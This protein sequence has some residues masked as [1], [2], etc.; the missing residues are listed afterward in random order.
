MKIGT[1]DKKKVIAASVLGFFGIVSAIF[2]YEQIF[3]GP[4]T[5]PPRPVVTTASAPASATPVA[6]K[7]AAV[8]AAPGFAVGTPQKLATTGG[9]L[10]PTLHM[11]AM[12]VTESLVYS[13]TGR[14]I[15]AMGPAEPAAPVKIEAAKFSPRPVVAAPP[16]PRGPTGPPPPPPINLKF[17]GTATSLKDNVR[18]AFLLIGD[19]V[20]YVSAGDV[21]QRR[22]RIISIAAN[23][24]LVEDIPNNNKQTLPLVAQ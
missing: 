20:L 8:T 18:R 21:V 15:F 9:E 13:G 7:T 24:I 14:N 10:D 16:P 23:S 2:L 4:S 17:F 6:A 19:D 11:E 5:P 3:G 22:Y 12:L 1:E